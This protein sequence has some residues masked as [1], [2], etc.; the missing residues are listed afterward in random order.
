MGQISRTRVGRSVRVSPTR[1]GLSRS[2]VTAGDILL[3]SGTEAERPVTRSDAGPCRPDR[4]VRPA[5]GAPNGTV[6]RELDALNPA[7]RR[8]TAVERCRLEFR[9]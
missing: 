4:M 5:S 9:V 3:G 8:P 7:S 2:A 1:E 6:G